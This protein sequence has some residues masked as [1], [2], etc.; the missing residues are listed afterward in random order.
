MNP[1]QFFDQA[2][3][4]AQFLEQHGQDTDR[5]RWQQIYDM[6]LLNEAQSQLL[7]NFVRQINVMVLAGAW[8]GDC[9]VQ[10]P[11][12]Q[13]FADATDR[14]TLRFIDR[15]TF[16]ELKEQL[17]ICGGARVPQVLFFNEDMQYVGH[18][19]DRTVSKY[20]DMTETITG[21]SCS[22]GMVTPGDNV[23]E[24]VIQDWLQEFE[25]IQLICRT[26]P[27]LREKHGD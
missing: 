8:C 2:L 23:H 14:I 6:S 25:R 5:H 22:T 12:F 13:R 9:V 21:A 4:Y 11:I 16:P 10:C 24:R 1:A 3:T 7:G 27:R 26:S 18:Y 20:R 19:G 17:T 15:D